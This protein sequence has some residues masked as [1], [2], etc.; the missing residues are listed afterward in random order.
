[1]R[2]LLFLL[3]ATALVGCTKTSGPL[4]LYFIGSTRFTSGNR[5]AGPADTLATR[6][7]IDDTG[8]RPAGLTHLRI[9]VDY[10]PRRAPY[11]YPS[12]ITSFMFASVTPATEQIVY[13][14]SAFATSSTSA[15]PTELLFTNVYGAR[16][17]TG[18]ER[19]TYQVT[20]QASNTVSRTFIISQR[21]ADSTLVYNDYTLRLNT[22]P[23]GP[24]ARRFIDLKSGLALPTFTVAKA[25]ELQR[26][27]D[28]I[29]L[30]DGS[31]ASPDALVAP[32]LNDATWPMANRVRTR[33][34]KT[35]LTATTFLNVTDTLSI[36]QLF[37]APG[38]ST[39]PGLTVGDVYAFRISA[40][41]SSPFPTQYGLLYVVSST[42]GLQVQ[43]RTSKKPL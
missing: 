17:S 35:T 42:S 36:R 11:A 43:I 15:L 41:T 24:G 2:F 38:I 9:T 22:P 20:D 6:L 39:L 27:T 7:Y 23:I 33:F 14:D 19:W 8:A 30:A 18:T 34:A 16:T 13:L 29:L 5:A 25:P 37:A 21:R 28:V 12:P 26:L 10:S 40:S 32:R 3:L 31:L 1:M 4:K